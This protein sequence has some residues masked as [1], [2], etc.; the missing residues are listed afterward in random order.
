[1]KTLHLLCFF[2]CATVLNAAD[3][4]VHGRVYGQDEKGE[5]LGPIAGARIELKSETGGDVATV[6]TNNHGYYQIATLTPGAYR[7]KV[8]AAGFRDED[9]QRGFAMPQDTREFVH[10][11][12]LSR[13]PKANSGPAQ[14]NIVQPAVH[15]RVYGQDEKGGSRAAARREDRAA[16]RPGR[17]RGGHRDGEFAGRLL[18]DQKPASRRL[19]VSRLS[20]PDSPR[21]TPDAASPCQKRRSNTCMTSCCQRRRQ[22]AIAAI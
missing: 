11:F 14:S 4:G 22:S 9:E 19:R 15:G 17:H 5:N 10:D 13:E 7:Y 20:A 18:R 16:I 1:M 6:T 2:L 8:A 12:L 3:G 21:R